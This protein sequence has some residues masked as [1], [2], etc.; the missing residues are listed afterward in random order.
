[1]N[2]SASLSPW[3]GTKPDPTERQKSAHHV[4]PEGGGG[5]GTPYN[6]IYGRLHP[7]GVPFS[8]LRYM[9]G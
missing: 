3:K 9:E 2:P 1:M 4:A 5:G 8:D 6:G 7:K